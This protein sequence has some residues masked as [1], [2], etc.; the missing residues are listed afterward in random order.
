MTVSHQ[1]QS[2]VAIRLTKCLNSDII[3][4]VITLIFQ[5]TTFELWWLSGDKREGTGNQNCAVLYYACVLY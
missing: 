5:F 2:G 3:S 1:K 4:I